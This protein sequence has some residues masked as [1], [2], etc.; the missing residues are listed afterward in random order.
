MAEKYFRDIEQRD[1]KILIRRMNFVAQG[2]A[3][4][5]RLQQE[6]LSTYDDIDAESTLVTEL[7]FDCDDVMF[8]ILDEMDTIVR[9]AKELRVY[10]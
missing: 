2:I 1:M 10:R 6:Y 3:D 8:A 5:T 9:T 7:Q 4:F